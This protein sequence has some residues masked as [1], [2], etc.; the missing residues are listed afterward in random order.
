MVTSFMSSKFIFFLCPFLNPSSHH[1]I[2]SLLIS[3]HLISS[4]CLISSNLISSTHLI[5]YPHLVSS[6]PISS[7]LLISSHILIL[8]HLISSHHNLPSHPLPSCSLLSFPLLH[9]FISK[10]RKNLWRSTH[11]GLGFCPFNHTVLTKLFLK[12]TAQFSFR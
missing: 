5:S 12:D 3:S 10:N 4:F 6:H 1:L 7:N 2:S 11:E 9:L 8:S